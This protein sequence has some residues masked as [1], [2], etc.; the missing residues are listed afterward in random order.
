MAI[1]I[2]FKNLWNYDIINKIPE[3]TPKGVD[4]IYLT[5]NESDDNLAKEYGYIS[6]MVKDYLEISD[7]FERRKII[8]Y[9]NCYPE[10]VF[11]ELE[12]YT[13]VFICDS[14]II[15]FD[16]DYTNFI[17][18]VSIDRSLYVTS[19]YYRDNAD[20]IYEEL[21]R[22]LTVMRWKYNFNE[23]K[24]ACEK[25]EK[26]LRDRGLDMLDVRVCSAKYI[27]WNIVNKN[28]EM[29]SKFVYDEYL[30]H[31]QGNIIFS[32]ASK[33]YAEDTCHFSSGFFN[34]KLSDH[35]KNY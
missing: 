4:C 14:N 2:L 7:S 30:E 25:Y 33:I 16:P 1:C 5:D 11:R 15:E 17:E 8:A 24:L 26:M 3:N 22:S 12:K 6:Y 35:A 10:K 23:M 19:G 34:G 9:I 18:S 27:G 31:L 21:K 29:I 32:I 20:T 13:Y 28:K